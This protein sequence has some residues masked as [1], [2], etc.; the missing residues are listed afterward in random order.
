M[1]E[2]VCLS[3][4]WVAD[5]EMEKWLIAASSTTPVQDTEIIFYT[6]EKSHSIAVP[7]HLGESSWQ[8]QKFFLIKELRG[9]TAGLSYRRMV[10]FCIED[11][12]QFHC[13]TTTFTI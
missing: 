2:A 3:P 1:T 10:T 11:L 8:Q 9:I 4:G 6:S 7:A 12:F 5:S 13:R